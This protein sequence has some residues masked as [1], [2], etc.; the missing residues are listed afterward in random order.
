LLDI[1]REPVPGAGPDALLRD[2]A[3]ELIREAMGDE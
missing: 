3:E 2:A 1:G